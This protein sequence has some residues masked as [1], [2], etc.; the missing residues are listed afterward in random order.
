M[1]A[2]NL[3]SL[4]V[5]SKD[6][7]LDKG[8]RAEKLTFDFAEIKLLLLLLYGKRVNNYEKFT[9]LLNPILFS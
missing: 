5:N 3:F 4:L 6:Q 9:D 1:I 2:L 8:K 7:R